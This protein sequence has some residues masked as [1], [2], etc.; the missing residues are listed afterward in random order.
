MGTC[1]K[2]QVPADAY[3]AQWHQQELSRLKDPAAQDQ[4]LAIELYSA[5]Q[6]V[7]AI[8]SALN[9]QT[10][11]LWGLGN[12]A[13]GTTFQYHTSCHLWGWCRACLLHKQLYCML[14]RRTQ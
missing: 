12:D 8:P 7:A 11:L 3:E 2:S 6:L 9:A 13:I 14:P 10:R 5:W 1:A 4:G